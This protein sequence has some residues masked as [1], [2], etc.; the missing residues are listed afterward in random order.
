MLDLVLAQQPH[1]I[2]LEEVTATS[3]AQ[4]LADP[5]I[6]ALYYNS[7]STGATFANV[8]GCCA[9]GQAGFVGGGVLRG[10]Y[11][12]DDESH[13]DLRLLQAQS[14]IRQLWRDSP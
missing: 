8:R 13:H 9:C 7:D 1:A 5:R 6:Q 3:L 14:D 4:V 11:A 10:E 2:A 12:R